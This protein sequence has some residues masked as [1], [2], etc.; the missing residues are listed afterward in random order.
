MATCVFCDTKIDIIPD[1]VLRWCKCGIL[2]VDCSPEYTR[3]LGSKPIEQLKQED[4]E[5]VNK[6]KSK[7]KE[8]NYFKII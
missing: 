5:Y 2:G 4:L 8:P 7:M 3:Y 1:K 6:L